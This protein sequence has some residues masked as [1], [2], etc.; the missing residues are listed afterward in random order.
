MTVLQLADSYSD[1]RQHASKTTTS[2]QHTPVSTMSMATSC[3]SLLPPF[4][5]DAGNPGISTS[6]N[7]RV[8]R[9]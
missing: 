5:A 9:W 6:S 2:Q 4:L 8:S 3:D 7:S 1:C